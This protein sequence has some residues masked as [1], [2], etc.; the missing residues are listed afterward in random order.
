MTHLYHSVPKE[1][2]G[3]ILYPLNE[4]KTIYPEIY[5]KERSKYI[6]REEVTQQI[7]P[8]LDCL[9]NDVLHFSAVH[10]SIIKSA[11]AEAGDQV[12][13][14]RT[15]YEVDPT[16]LDLEKTVIYLYLYKDKNKQ[17]NWAAYDP[18]DLDKY[19]LIPQ[20]TK[21]YYKKMLERNERPLLYHGIPHILYRGTLD[22]TKL[23]IVS[24]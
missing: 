24:P 2:V 9:W 20:F 23:R 22:T 10:P 21:D 8:K 13:L 6:G 19:S 16:L 17:E 12:N 18:R 15:Y 4:L 7:I 1:L 3:N 14:K 11:L 5:A